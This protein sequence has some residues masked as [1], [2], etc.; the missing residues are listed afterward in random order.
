MFT[1]RLL[2]MMIVVA[3][4]AS[5]ADN[6]IDSSAACAVKKNDTDLVVVKASRT[7]RDDNIKQHN[8]V[9]FSSKKI[10]TAAGAAND[11]SRYLATLPS[12]VSS[13][14][15]NFDNTL[16]VRGGRPSEIM[17]L[18]DGIEF[19]NINHFSQADGC[20]GPVGFLNSD[21]IQNV[22]FYAGTI[23]VSYP[24]R[25]SSIVDIDM[26]SGSFSQLTGNA[27]LKLT[28][29]LASIEKPVFGRFGSFALAGRYID[30][31]TLHAFIR[32]D[33]IP[34]LGDAYGKIMLLINKNLTVSGTGLFS[35]NTYR[36]GYPVTEQ[37]DDGTMFP[38]SLNEKDKILQGG[39]G[40]YLHYKNDAVEHRIY[41]NFSARNGTSYDSLGEFADS[42]FTHH[43]A[44][45]PV[46]D[47]QDGRF[48]YTASSVSSISVGK[49]QTFSAG[50][51]LRENRY[52]FMTS[53][54]SQHDGTCIICQNDTPVTVYWTHAAMEK[55][56]RL[57][58]SEVGLFGDHTIARGPW[59]SCL[60]VRAD[61]F[62]L[63]DDIAISPRIS[64]M[65]S[66]GRAGNLTGGFG[67][68]HQFP[69]DLPAI[70]FNYLSGFPGMSTDS[71][72]ASA[73]KLLGRAEPLRCWQGSVGYDITPGGIS[74][75]RC[76]AYYKWYDREY[77]FIAPDLQDVLYMTPDGEPALG[78]Q[79]GNRKAYGLEL[80][81]TSARQAWYFYSLGFSL[82][83]VKNRFDNT[84]WYN[85]W[86]NV[87]YTYSLAAGATFLKYHCFSLS[88][89][90][91]GG[92]PFCPEITRQDCIGR[93]FAGIDK[94]SPY[95]GQRLQGLITTNVRY[96][97]T[98]RMAGVELE[99]NIEIINLLNYKPVLE[100]KFN[101]TGFQKVTP[102]GI[103]P[104]I[105]FIVHF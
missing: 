72:R 17:F 104:I 19:E 88:V 28:G 54:Q 66:F 98:R 21:Y 31:S 103:T 12:V 24:S 80:S 53:D 39:A 74:R 10:K 35:Y 18:V 45:N 57:D 46:R 51:R 81:V 63:L 13:L 37:G 64:Q 84:Q 85:D 94:N 70:I 97:F 60:G 4:F 6:G 33:G 96:G 90:G 78:P 102:F 2:V 83:D 100:Y 3:R 73:Q 23:P 8:A 101:G 15:A 89:Q 44:K 32:N 93:I 105:G 91:S 1:G 75:L 48:H 76:E 67:L 7:V 58:G 42:F 55:A 69:T 25:I 79:D 86:T 38:N 71:M 62:G 61:Y 41:A 65:L 27:G 40:V 52:E 87:G 14:G 50:A 26:K 56:M 68:Y 49:N 30:F 36:F 95:Y 34:Q 9:S 92:R 20:G 47:Q 5:A 29:G 82:F 99:S 77:R 16:Y 43:Y 11:L 59:Q 22:R